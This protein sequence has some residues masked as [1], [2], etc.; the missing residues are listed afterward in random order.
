MMTKTF[1]ITLPTFEGLANGI[2]TWVQGLYVS[3]V[4]TIVP[5][6]V[7]ILLAWLTPAL[8][9]LGI[10]LDEG[11]LIAVGVSVLAGL[12]YG[13]ARTFENQKKYSWLTKIGGYMLGIPKTPT[14]VTPVPVV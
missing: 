9:W 7:A 4:R 12:W 1:E 14:Y 13:V 10:Q 11:T 5:Y 6:G 2:A 3:Y 8:N